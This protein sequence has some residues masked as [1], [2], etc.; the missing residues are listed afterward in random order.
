MQCSK[1][2]INVQCKAQVSSLIIV[3]CCFHRR[4]VKI[5]QVRLRALMPAW[6]ATSCLTMHYE[7]VVLKLWVVTHLWITTQFFVG[8]VAVLFGSRKV[9]C[10]VLRCKV[11]ITTKDVGHG[12]KMIE[13]TQFT[14]SQA[15]DGAEKESAE[16]RVP[17]VHIHLFAL[18]LSLQSSCVW[19]IVSISP[20]TS[21]WGCGLVSDVP[22]ITT[23]MKSSAWTCYRTFS[24]PLLP[25]SVPQLC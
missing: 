2:L 18:I 11:A 25:A 13:E 21:K 1:T 10:G 15:W 8:G 14:C 22:I 4:A 17:Q 20:I 9:F 7:A 5:L 6:I 24:R 16:W 12:G 23:L 3:K 19:L